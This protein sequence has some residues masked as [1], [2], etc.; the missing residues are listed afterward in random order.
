MNQIYKLNTFFFILF[1]LGLILP[2]TGFG[3]Q[4][5]ENDP[6]EESLKYL[7]WTGDIDNDFFNELN[8]REV[9]QRPARPNTQ[10]QLTKPECLPG[11]NKKPN[12]I[13]L[14]DHDPS[15]DKT[16]KGGT[17]TPGQPIPFNLYIEGA[18][19]V[20]MGEILF[21][22]ADFGMTLNG[23][24]LR[25]DHS[26]SQGIV[27]LDNE[28][29]LK[30]TA[31]EISGYT[32]YDF[33]DAASWIYWK[34]ITPDQFGTS[35]DSKI[36]LSG[37]GTTHGRG[38]RINQYY[39]KG[40]LIRPID[41]NYTTLTIFSETDFGGFQGE[42]NELTIYKGAG[43]PNGMNNAARS[44]ILKKGY[45]AT[46]AVNENGTSKGKVYIASEEDMYVESLP[47]ALLGNVSFIRVV[48]WNWVTKKGTGGFIDGLD[49][50]WFYSWSANN[51]SR[52]NYEYVPMAWGA[53]GASP[54]TVQ[55]V[56]DKSNVSHF[57]GFNESD[58]CNGESGQF[59][60][61]CQPKVAVAYFEGLMASGLRIGSPAPRENGPTGWLREFNEIAK[62]RDVR[63]DFVAVHWYD[64]GSNPANSPNAD[65]VLIFNRFKAYLENVYRIYQMPI[66]ITE[67][68]AN[69]NRGNQIQE[70]FLKLALPYLEELE[71]VERYAYFQPD[72]RNSSNNVSTA[73]YF[74]ENGGLTNIGELYLNH[75]SSPSIKAAT[76]SPN[77]NLDGLNIPFAPIV[78]ESS[79]LEAE[80]GDYLGS[81]WDIIENTNASNGFVLRGNPQNDGESP[82][83][84]Q[85]HFE[86][87]LEAGDTYRIWFRGSTSGTNIALRLKMDNGPM[88]QIGGF[89][90]NDLNWMQVPR[91]YDLQEGKHRLTIEFTNNVMFLDQVAFVNGPVNLDP[92]MQ[93][94]GYCTPRDNFWGLVQSDLI[95]FYEAETA[96][97]GSA[98]SMGVGEKAI[99][100]LFLAADGQSPSLDTAPEGMGVISFDFEVEISDE[101][102]IWAKIQALELTTKGSLW[103]AVDDQPF[104]KF[105]DLQNDLFLWYWKKFHYTYETETRSFSYFLEAG[106]HTVKIAYAS[107]N[108][109]IDRIAVVSAGKSPAEV[110]PNVVNLR[111]NLE[112]E[113]ELATILGGAQI[114]TCGTSSN[115]QQVNMGTFVANVVLFDKIIALE[116]GSYKLQITYMSAV[117][118]PF[119]LVVNGQVMGR[120]DAM[121]SG[122]WCFNGGSP[123]IW[124][125]TVTLVEG[126]NSIR[127]TPIEGTAAPFVDKIKLEKSRR[128]APTF[129]S[130]EAEDAELVGS[131]PT[132]L[133]GT[134]SN[135]QI[136]NMGFNVNNQ[137]N[138]KNVNIEAAGVYNVAF[139]YFSNSVRKMRIITNGNS[140]IVDFGI[141]GAF[142]F[143]GGSPGS[144]IVELQLQAGDNV[145]QLTPI[146]GD[147][148]VMDKIVI[149]NKEADNQMMRLINDQEVAI[150]P[151]DRFENNEFKVYP[152]PVKAGEQLTIQVP[153]A[154]MEGALVMV[155]LTDMTGR[156]VFVEAVNN[157]ETQ[158]IILK[159]SLKKGIYLVLIQHGNQ[160]F[161]KKLKVE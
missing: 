51:N 161:T 26:I 106:A 122:E 103:V 36:T 79:I 57:L 44:F 81:Q 18:E 22:C 11:G 20:A 121:R 108:V 160:W 4:D 6:C 66:W 55:S 19:I 40:S 23:S 29:T 125:T 41:A 88:E 90:S 35:L 89:N 8:W 72:P 147:A 43:I 128:I 28:S 100:G 92:M 50:G 101:Y 124:E 63:F 143:A 30:I 115:G 42:L 64:W 127:I 151:S 71:Y 148:P 93:E 132:P 126:V 159:E 37:L 140:R 154:S 49:A 119:R 110:D 99:N 139:H 80:C 146:E 85:V 91:F 112:F 3:Y 32:R 58:N 97:F 9:V 53:G 68:N 61:L 24:M 47:E 15:K 73:F 84:R 1:G 75:E 144:Q 107:G 52:P 87:E 117:A 74:D 155:S 27:T 95:D 56:I 94:S 113:A 38:F 141:T 96:N 21:G 48:P 13:C 105:S 60:N 104:R 102:E 17:L 70:A 33:L 98:W 83:S 136:V 82:I 65:P 78:Y 138:F 16:P 133:C 14:S 5:S 62:A 120:Q 10:G 76:Y 31:S 77:N 158:S 12:V 153:G 123:A 109:A 59:N 118:R 142:C 150:S 156:R 39:Q 7:Y 135:G 145:I 69:P 45:M 25:S 134:A 111:E 2:Q 149:T 46:F 116:A 54:A 34:G 131:F 152:N 137:I 114:V 130:L 157:T 86:F 67:F 129:I